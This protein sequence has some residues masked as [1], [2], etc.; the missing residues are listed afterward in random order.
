RPSEIRD[1][2]PRA[3]RRA[4]RFGCGG[5]LRLLTAVV[6]RGEGRVPT[7]GPARLAPA[8]ARSAAAAQADRCC[9][10]RPRDGTH[11]RRRRP[12]RN[13]ARRHR[14]GPVRDH[15][16]SAQHRTESAALPRTAGKKTTLTPAVVPSDPQ[17]YEAQYETLRAQMTGGTAA[18]PRGVGL[19]LLM[20][21]GLTTWLH[22]VR[23]CLSP[24]P[25]DITHV[26][27]R[28][29][30]PVDASASRVMMRPP[31]ADMIPPAQ[32]AEAARL[33]VSLVLSARP[34]PR[35]PS[36]LASGAIR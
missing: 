7:R 25:P 18:I 5:R 17:I 22:A 12:A 28:A 21:E 8:E 9:P 29:I 20:H 36:H 31:P 30:A 24:S 11:R 35:H 15:R 27:T 3:R 14:E 33:I 26:A 13:G 10:G 1:A 4:A 19:A 34:V 2:A 16:A 23:P 6:L 32:H